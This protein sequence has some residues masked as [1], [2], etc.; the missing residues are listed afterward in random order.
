[1]TLTEALKKSKYVTRPELN[2]FLMAKEDDY[3]GGFTR[4]YI[5][6]MHGKYT[7]SHY[8]IGLDDVMSENW[9]PIKFEMI[10]EEME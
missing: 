1:M 3:E 9:I 7:S 5:S 6:Q 8:G 4:I 10:I 2:G